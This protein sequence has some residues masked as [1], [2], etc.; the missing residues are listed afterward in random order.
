MKAIEITKLPA[1]SI[2]RIKGVEWIRMVDTNSPDG[3][4]EGIF[5]PKDGDWMPWFY[6]C[7][8]ND[9]VELIRKIDAQALAHE[10]EQNSF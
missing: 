8:D 7:Y 6:L 3:L 5:N 9:E 1:G 10:A 2:V 4:N